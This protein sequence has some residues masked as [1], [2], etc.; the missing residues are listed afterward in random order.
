[1]FENEVSKVQ[2]VIDV[3]NLVFVYRMTV[4][5]C[6]C[7]QLFARSG[8]TQLC[9]G[10]CTVDVIGYSSDQFFIVRSFS[11]TVGISD[12]DLGQNGQ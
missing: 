7:N 5:L 8:F 12:D 6:T 10:F 11:D 2:D 4:R 1:M 9:P 3:V